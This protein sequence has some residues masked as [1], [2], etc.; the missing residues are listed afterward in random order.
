[1]AILMATFCS[2]GHTQGY[3]LCARLL[4]RLHSKLMATPM[5]TFYAHGSILHQWLQ[6]RLHFAL[7]APLMATS[8]THAYAHSWLRSWLHFTLMATLSATYYTHGYTH[9]WVHFALMV[10]Q[11]RTKPQMKLKLEK[12]GLKPL[13]SAKIGKTHVVFLSKFRKAPNIHQHPLCF[14]TF[15]KKIVY[16]LLKFYTFLKFKSFSTFLLT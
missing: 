5:A 3:I 9:P 14:S 4:S 8:Y 12:C 7:M 6:V 16:Q 15:S 1:M 10:L 2:H 13:F 11:R